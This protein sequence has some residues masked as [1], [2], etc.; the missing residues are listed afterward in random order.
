MADLF[1]VEMLNVYILGYINLICKDEDV[2]LIKMDRTKT[3]VVTDQC[4]L[5]S[6]WHFVRGTGVCS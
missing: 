6:S 4:E 3:I 2:L 1:P 5:D